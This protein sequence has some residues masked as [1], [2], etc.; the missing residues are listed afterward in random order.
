[1]VRLGL[2]VL[3][4]LTACTCSAQSCPDATLPSAPQIAFGPEQ[5]PESLIVSFIETAKASIRV[6]AFA[7]S[8]PVIVDA[9]GDAVR[10][11]VDV[12][13][14]IDYNHNIID[15][16]KWIGRN[17]ASAISA[18]GATLHTN[19]KYRRHHDKFIVID[20]CHVQ[21]GSWNYA[22]SARLNSENVIVLWNAPDVAKAYLSH[23][24]SRFDEGTA[25]K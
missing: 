15:D 6:S 22:S 7:F 2:L 14:V 11:G 19:S 21:T 8:S 23:W 17:A 9:L 12:Q 24:Q 10:R 1:M 13:L 4:V 5:S 20:A 18:A 16:P 3:G 25:Y